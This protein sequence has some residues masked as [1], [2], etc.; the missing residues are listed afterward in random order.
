MEADLADINKIKIIRAGT[1]N[2]LNIIYKVMDEELQK[3]IN[4]LLK[5]RA[6]GPDSITNKV[7]YI[8]APLILKELA[9]AVIKYL[10]IGLPKGL[11]E[12]FTLILKKKGKKDYLLLNTYR[13]I[14]LKNILVKLAEKVL[15]IYIIEKIEV[16]TLL[17]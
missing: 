11:K 16:K 13:P 5:D 2:L 1:A 3:I 8:I 9:Q 6:L 4:K 17:L 14:A 12:L 15:I 10:I 7:I